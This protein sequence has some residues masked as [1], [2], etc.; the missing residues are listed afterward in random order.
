LIKKYI[1]KYKKRLFTSSALSRPIFQYIVWFILVLSTSASG[2]EKDCG[3]EIIRLI[4]NINPDFASGITERAWIPLQQPI[5][6]DTWTSLFSE[7]SERIFA[8]LFDKLILP[9][10]EKN[11]SSDLI[12]RIYKGALTESIWASDVLTSKE[13]DERKTIE[14]QLFE[15][16]TKNPKAEYAK[17]LEMKEAY[18]KILKELSPIPEHQWTNVQRVKKERAEYKL[19]TEG[20]KERFEKLLDRLDT[21]LAQDPERFRTRLLQLLE[22]NIIEKTP[23][24]IYKTLSSPSLDQLGDEDVWTKVSQTFVV[25]KGL[26]EDD[27]RGDIWLSL[28][29]A[30][31]TI[32]SARNRN[33]AQIEGWTLRLPEG[34]S[35]TI[36]A[37]ILVGEI[38][39]PW[40][41]STF[42]RSRAWKR[43]VET[44]PPLSKGES[45]KSVVS[46]YGREANSQLPVLPVRFYMTRSVKLRAP[47]PADFL[48]RITRHKL[49]GNQIWLGP[50]K[51][52]GTADVGPNT[53]SSAVVT[54]L[55]RNS[56][57]IHGAIQ[58]VGI[59]VI[60]VPQSPNPHPDFQWK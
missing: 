26:C 57:H 14:K 50:V 46:T 58:L 45:I 15:E 2:A 31:W 37:E 47:F 16:G 43:R 9:A 1:K 59:E 6:F 33:G 11:F 5:V 60:P 29:P 27:N 4:L 24:P 20:Q 22:A 41:D 35:V 30:N 25:K 51:M 39:R 28:M 13:R 34:S 48:Q 54:F 12:S 38:I 32:I 49:A 40:L 7:G 55:G 23:T 36:E 56:L 17:Y 21:L 52:F 10:K 3:T 19:E 44:D 42:F 53:S 8:D 18:E